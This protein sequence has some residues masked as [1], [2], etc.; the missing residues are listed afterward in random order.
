MDTFGVASAGYWWGRA[1]AALT[2]LAHYLQGR[3]GML[4]LMLCSDDSWATAHGERADRDL[5]LHLLVLGVL[6]TP[7]AWHKLKG[8]AELEWIGYALDVARFEI[9]ISESRVKWAIRWITDKIREGAV[10]LCELREGLG[11]LQFVAGP[12]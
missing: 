7:L 11:R 1:G 4:W 5:L 8:G 10:R 2:R 12:L 9:G 3:S 6:G